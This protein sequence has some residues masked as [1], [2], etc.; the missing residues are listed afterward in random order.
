[1]SW[2]RVIPRFRNPELDAET[3][4]RLRQS[5][6]PPAAPSQ[7]DIE[8]DAAIRA[9]ERE[10]R[11]LRVYVAALIRLLAQK[12]AIDHTEVTGLVELADRVQR[13]IPS[14]NYRHQPDIRD[15]IQPS[16]AA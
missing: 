10:T 16:E 13:Q 12:E 6:R 1:M 14:S 2:N 11:E 5:A 15:L 4:R 9:L 8:Q 3:E 7:K